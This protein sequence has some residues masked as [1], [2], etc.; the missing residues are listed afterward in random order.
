MVHGREQEVP[1][2]RHR[3]RGKRRSL[4]DRGENSERLVAGAAFE[5]DLKR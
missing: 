5:S 4:E 2:A 1:P 3:T